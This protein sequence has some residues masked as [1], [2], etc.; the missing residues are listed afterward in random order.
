MTVEAKVI[1]AITVVFDVVIVGLTLGM[2]FTNL[3]DA[4]SPYGT[5]KPERQRKIG[6]ERAKH[7]ALKMLYVW[8]LGAAVMTA[9][10]FIEGYTNVIYCAGLAVIIISAVVFLA[11]YYRNTR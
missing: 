4:C 1:L 2:R 9:S 7:G 10:V 8:L 11:W 6:R 5:D 3:I